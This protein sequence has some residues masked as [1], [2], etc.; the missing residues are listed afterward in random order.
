MKFEF[1][2][3]DNPELIHYIVDCIAK[4]KKGDYK[5]E[6]SPQKIEIIEKPAGPKPIQIKKEYPP[7]ERECAHCHQLEMT[8]QAR[9]IFICSKC[10]PHKGSIKVI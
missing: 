9:G 2:E 3:T 4:F 10:D 6:T 8:D 5:R 1:N 7:R